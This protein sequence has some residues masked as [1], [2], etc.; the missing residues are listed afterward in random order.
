MAPPVVGKGQSLQEDGTRDI[1]QILKIP[2]V[3]ELIAVLG[4][5]QLQ[6][7]FDEYVELR[8]SIETITAKDYTPRVF[9][10]LGENEPNP[11]DMHRWARDP[12]SDEPWAEALFVYRVKG[13][14]ESRDCPAVDWKPVDYWTLP[15]V[16]DQRHH[17][18]V[19][20]EQ[21]GFVLQI[22]ERLQ[23]G[24]YQKALTD[25]QQKIRAEVDLI[26][27]ESPGDA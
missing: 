8:P 2:S 23:E 10:M 5:K 9:A 18:A 22:L 20:L 17:R 6:F 1:A 25:V 15:T 19:W 11:T 3:Q 12:P 7:A 4:E 16:E 24:R 13:H 27:G 14:L 26:K 21:Y